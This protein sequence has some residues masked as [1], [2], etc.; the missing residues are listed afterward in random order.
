MLTRS[1]AVSPTISSG[2]RARCG[3]RSPY[4]ATRTASRT[5]LASWAGISTFSAVQWV[6]R[7]A[8]EA[9]SRP[10]APELDVVDLDLTRAIPERAELE[11]D[12][13]DVGQ[14][15]V[16]RSEVRDHERRQRHPHAFER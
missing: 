12:R 9:T 13:L 4:T 7:R 11:R 16:I 14:V 6:R 3:K 2:I 8:W 5:S 15:D 10:S 1:A